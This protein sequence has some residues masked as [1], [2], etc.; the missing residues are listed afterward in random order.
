[1]KIQRLLV[2]SQ[3]FLE[4]LCL[5]NADDLRTEVFLFVCF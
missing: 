5:S 4:N 1:M 3:V 2:L